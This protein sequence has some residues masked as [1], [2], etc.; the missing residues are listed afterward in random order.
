MW[1]HHQLSLTDSEFNFELEIK[2]GVMDSS[3]YAVHFVRRE[4]LGFLVG[5]L[6]FESV[7]DKWLYRNLK[8]L[9]SSP[10]DSA[11]TIREQGCSLYC[12]LESLNKFFATAMLTNHREALEYL[13]NG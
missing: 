10:Q 11:L 12:S 9:S 8:Y 1:A 13:G 2:K 7:T 4:Q 3:K 5:V 6:G